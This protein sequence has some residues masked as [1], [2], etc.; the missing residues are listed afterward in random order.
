VAEEWLIV[1]VG[2]F[3]VS[4]GNHRSDEYFC[5]STLTYSVCIIILFMTIDKVNR[6]QDCLGLEESG[7]FCA[8]SWHFRIAQPISQ[9]LLH[10]LE[11]AYRIGSDK[12]HIF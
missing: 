11:C 12:C 1:E 5:P 3:E 9:N 10:H 6:Q 4:L 7:V 8:I 2:Y